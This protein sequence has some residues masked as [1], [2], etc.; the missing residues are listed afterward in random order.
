MDDAV[1]ESWILVR[2]YSHGII[3]R[4]SSN[5]LNV[6]DLLACCV[7]PIIAHLITE[8]TPKV[9]ICARDLRVP[10]SALGGSA[11]GTMPRQQP[12]RS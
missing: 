5:A 1:W 9:L 2:L 4:S 3:V 6:L 8:T 7:Q 11:P 12:L 10:R